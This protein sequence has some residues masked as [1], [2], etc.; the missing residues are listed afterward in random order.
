LTFGDVLY[1]FKQELRLWIA[2]NRKRV[3]MEEA[4]G[5]MRR[6]LPEPE[7]AIVAWKMA[8]ARL[9]NLEMLKEEGE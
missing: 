2:G 3:M 4:D 7:G 5:V 1:Q 6:Y 9:E 8:L